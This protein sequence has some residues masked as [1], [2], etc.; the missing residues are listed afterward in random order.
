MGTLIK[1]IIIIKQAKSDPKVLDEMIL[2]AK[3]I[4]CEKRT[5]ILTLT[6][7]GSL[8]QYARGIP[9]SVHWVK[10]KVVID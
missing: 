7:I 4:P 1:S 9:T 8:V 6:L 3:I 10:L 2:E 5:L